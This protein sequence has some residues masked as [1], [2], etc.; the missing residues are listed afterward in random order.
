MLQTQISSRLVFDAPVWSLLYFKDKLPSPNPP[1]KIL[2]FQSLSSSLVLQFCS[3]VA[4]LPFVLLMRSL[5]FGNNC[6]NPIMAPGRCTRLHISCCTLD[7]TATSTLLHHH[8]RCVTSLRQTWDSRCVTVKVREELAGAPPG[9]SW[10]PS[11]FH[12]FDLC[13]FPLALSHLAVKSRVFA[14]DQP[15]LTLTGDSRNPK[16]G[17]HQWDVQW[18]ERLSILSLCVTPVVFRAFYSCV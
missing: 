12:L 7:P 14:G 13:H 9:E 16:Q 11:H 18:C 4:K 17:T 6:A 8:R 10:T 5:P 15:P 3:W 2:N 1:R